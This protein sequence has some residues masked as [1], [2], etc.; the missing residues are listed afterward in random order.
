MP[1]L[2]INTSHTIQRQEDFWEKVWRGDEEYCN[3]SSRKF[4]CSGWWQAPGISLYLLNQLL[5]LHICPR[6]LN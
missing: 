2:W 6:G 5:Y 3:L 4:P 1:C